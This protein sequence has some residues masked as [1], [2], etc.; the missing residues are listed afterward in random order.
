MINSGPDVKFD[1]Y[2]HLH[3]EFKSLSLYSVTA[4]KN[5]FDKKK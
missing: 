3:T 4:R 5:N 2:L 1:D